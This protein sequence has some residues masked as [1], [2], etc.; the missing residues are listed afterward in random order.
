MLYTNPHL[1]R[2]RPRLR[3][4]CLVASYRARIDSLVASYR[5]TTGNS[6]TLTLT[7]T[8]TLIVLQQGTA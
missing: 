1:A 8:L 7:L 4:D 5:A 2:L 6:L 3:P